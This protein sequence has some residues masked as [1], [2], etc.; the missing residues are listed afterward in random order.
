MKNEKKELIFFIIILFIILIIAF[1]IIFSYYKITKLSSNINNTT[2]LDDSTLYGDETGTYDMKNTVNPLND[3]IKNKKNYQILYISCNTSNDLFMEHYF[4][5]L[6]NKVVHERISIKGYSQ[7]EMENLSKNINNNQND[8]YDAKINGDLIIYSQVGNI[9]RNVNEVIN[10]FNN[11]SYT[12][13]N[14]KQ[15]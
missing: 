2:V 13:V 11:G 8:I 12:N 3:I 15:I 7:E 4:I 14:I 9:T 5:V 10:S 6:D 1:F